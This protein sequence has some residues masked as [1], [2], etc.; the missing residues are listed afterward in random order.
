MGGCHLVVCTIASAISSCV[1]S[2]VSVP[3]VFPMALPGGNR[4][5]YG[6]ESGSGSLKPQREAQFLLELLKMAE[7]MRPPRRSEVPPVLGEIM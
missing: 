5:T 2:P 1:R 6:R 3:K 7:S 4:S